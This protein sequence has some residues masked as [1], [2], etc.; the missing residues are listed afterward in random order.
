MEV[1]AR[2]A[3]SSRFTARARQGHGARELFSSGRCVKL[4]G[5]RRRSENRNMKFAFSEQSPSLADDWEGPSI[6]RLTPEAPHPDPLPRGRGA[7]FLSPLPPGAPLH[8]P[9]TLSPPE[10]A[11]SAGEGHDCKTAT[12]VLA[13]LE[14]VLRFSGHSVWLRAPERKRQ[15]H[16]SDARRRWWIRFQFMDCCA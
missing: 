3:R 8:R 15:P 7:G 16:L 9:P 6:S 4:H 1:D 10:A 2:Y 13:D 14:H 5:V 12:L 11:H